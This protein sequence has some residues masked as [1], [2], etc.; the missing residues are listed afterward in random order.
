MP[1][2]WDS[3]VSHDLFLQTKYL[4]ALET[5]APYNIELFFIAVFRDASLVGVAVVQRV[6]LY[7]EDMFRKTQVSCVKE[8]F[9]NLVSKVLR[10]NILVV[11][12][13]TQT[14]QHGVYFNEAQIPYNAYLKC[15]SEALNT[16]KKDIKKKQGKTIR[17]ILFKDFFS[18][19]IKYNRAKDFSELNLHKVSV[20]PNMILTILDDWKTR[21]D[22]RSSLTKKYRDRYKRA[23]KKLAPTKF[24]ELTAE[25]ISSNA[26]TLHSLYLNVCNNAKFNTFIL[27]ASHFVALKT[28]LRERFK[29]VACFVE[30]KLIGFYSL[31]LNNSNLETYF[32]GYNHDYQQSHQLYLNM[33]YN[34][35]Q[36]GIEQEFKSVVYARTA[37]AI[38]SSVGA[39]PYPM[40]MYMKHTN[41]LL[42]LLLKPVF[43]LMNPKQDWEERH[44]FKEDYGSNKFV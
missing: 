35:L 41:A 15:L 9:Q 30:D 29:L 36:Y 28:N 1:K 4:K 37:M 20:Q 27:P 8:F 21:E 2:A 40:V 13:L 39:K 32:L 24:K 5:G 33:L 38:K 44:P 19:D 6:K 7:L 43:K 12:N 18:N 14:G 42:N 3:L 22:Y 31:I 26:E 34:M 25:E 16:L 23:H 11:G 17:L 10:G